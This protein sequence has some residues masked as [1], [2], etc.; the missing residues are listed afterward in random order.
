MQRW[1]DL[2][3][4][5]T[6][7]IKEY[8]AHAKKILKK[9]GKRGRLARIYLKEP[10]GGEWGDT[11]S[12]LPR[13]VMESLMMQLQAQSVFK[14]TEDTENPLESVQLGGH[15]EIEKALEDDM[16]KMLVAELPDGTRQVAILILDS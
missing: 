11:R 15:P 10:D 7:S 8:E 1:Y 5:R 6:Y 3:K 12:E 9:E 2:G 14:I 16:A 13:H 4:F